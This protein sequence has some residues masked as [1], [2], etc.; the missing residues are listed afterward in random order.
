MFKD[1][2]YVLYLYPHKY[3]VSSIEGIWT[4]SQYRERG[5]VAASIQS[6]E[7]IMDLLMRVCS[8]FSP[9]TT[10]SAKGFL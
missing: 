6:E 7:D 3:V 1:G 2:L 5:G 10:E 4:E 8:F 9:L